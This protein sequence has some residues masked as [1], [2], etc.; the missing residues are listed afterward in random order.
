VSAAKAHVWP[1][2]VYYEDTDAAGVV[3][4]A[5]YLKFAER[6]RTEMLVD[7]GFGQRQI[8]E[9][10]GVVFAVR[11]AEVDYR[12]PAF[13]DEQIEIHTSVAKVGGASIVLDQIVKRADINLV[14]MKI[15]LVC[16]RNDWRAGRVPQRVRDVLESMVTQPVA[17][18]ERT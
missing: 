7:A 18:D 12:L 2:R 9:E 17:Q 8:K 10:N 14:A 15:T 11:M 5:N 13:L 16:I 3:Y 6:A 1:L 4:Y